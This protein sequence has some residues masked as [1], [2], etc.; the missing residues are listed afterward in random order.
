MAKKITIVENYKAV[1][2]FLKENEA[3]EEML[4]FIADRKDKQSKKTANRKPTKTQTEN[5]SIKVDILANMEPDKAYTIGEIQTMVGLASNQK[6]SALVRQLK[7]SGLVD[8]SEIKGRA[9]FTKVSD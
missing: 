7:E 1:L 3:P 8:R 2:A 5:E 4:A 6:T 9:Y